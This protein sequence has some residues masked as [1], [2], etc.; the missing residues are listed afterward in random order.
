MFQRLVDKQ[1]EPQQQQQEEQQHHH[2]IIVSVLIVFISC[3][4]PSK[5]QFVCKSEVVWYVFLLVS[6]VGLYVFRP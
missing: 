4:L 6:T 1:E 3:F 5:F 2:I